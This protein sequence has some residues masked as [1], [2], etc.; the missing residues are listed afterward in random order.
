[1]KPCRSQTGKSEMTG[2]HQTEPVRHE[3]PLW[4]Q[5]QA[6]HACLGIGSSAPIPLKKSDFK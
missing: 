2:N 4:G 1:L 3:G 6:S 5:L